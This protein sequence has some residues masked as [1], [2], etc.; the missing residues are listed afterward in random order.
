VPVAVRLWLN[1]AAE[2]SL[3]AIHAARPGHLEIEEWGAYGRAHW[4]RALVVRWYRQD[5]AAVVAA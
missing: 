3:R 1:I 2:N 5:R 4:G